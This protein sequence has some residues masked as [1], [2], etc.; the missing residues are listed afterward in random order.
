MDPHDVD[1]RPGRWS[2]GPAYEAYL[3]RWSRRLARRFVDWV[4]ADRDSHWLDVGCGTGALSEAIV[5]S[6]EPAS[7]SAIDTSEGFV[8]VARETVPDPRIH[9]LLADGMHLPFADGSFDIVASGLILHVFEDPAAAVLEQVRVTRAG[10]IV[11]G[12]I[13]DDEVGLGLDRRF[14][15][16]AVVLEPNASEHA[17][18]ARF[19]VSEPELLRGLFE[20]AGLGA[21]A[22]T[23]IEIETAFES[24]DDLWRPFTLGQGRAPMYLAAQSPMRQSEIREAYGEAVPPGADGTIRLRAR[25]VAIRGERPGPTQSAVS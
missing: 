23:T 21:V 17:S 25:V 6:A 11:A 3:G 12:Y 19:G 8:T 20:A 18:K 22:T 15:D 24:F 13:W 5:A 16:V 4:G 2:D 10:G 7:V 9:Y 1:R 14:W